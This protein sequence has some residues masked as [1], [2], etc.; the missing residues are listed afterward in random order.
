[1][2]RLLLALTT[3]LV[4][5]LAASSTANAAPYKQVI[6]NASKRFKATSDWGVSKY[7]SQKA[8]KNYRFIRPKRGAGS[9]RFVARFPSRGN[10]AIYARW[11]ANSG[12]NNRARFLVKTTRGWKVRVVNQRRNG[13]K[14]VRLGIYNMAK[15]NGSYIRVAKR[16]SGR[17]Y[18]IADAVL[19]KKV[20]P[21]TTLT[22]RQKVMREARS[23]LG[24]PYRYGGE[25]RRGV[26]CS[27]LTM[28]VFQKVNVSLPRTVPAQYRRGRGTGSPRVSDLAF[29]DYNESGGV[30]HV[31]IY[32]GRGRTINAPYPGTVVRYDPVRPRYH[33]GYRK[34]LR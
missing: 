10:Y 13:G 14:W 23:W 33:V 17:G 20:Q 24:T 27:G 4:V 31:G 12:Y 16:S 19:V 2:S 25:S 11:P 26:D 8:G 7:S 28:R 34:I 29:S 6:D 18:I 22:R 3:A 5:S 30:G 15:G 1:M 9:A 21:K 32:S